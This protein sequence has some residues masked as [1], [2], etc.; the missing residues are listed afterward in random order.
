MTAKNIVLVSVLA[1]LVAAYLFSSAIITAR[2]KKDAAIIPFESAK[3]Q[4]FTL[5]NGENYMTVRREPDS[6]VFAR[7][8]DGIAARKETVEM[9]FKV[10]DKLSPIRRLGVIKE[11]ELEDFGILTKSPALAVTVG[12]KT[13]EFVLGARNPV[14]QSYYLYRKDTGELM[15][16]AEAAARLFR[17]RPEDFRDKKL[18]KFDAKDIKSM[19]IVIK[20]S[21]VGMVELRSHF[22]KA[23][24]SENS[25]FEPSRSQIGRAYLT[26]YVSRIW[27]WRRPKDEFAARKAFLKRDLVQKDWYL[28]E[29]R[30]GRLYLCEMA[31]VGQFIEMMLAAEVND[32]AAADDNYSIAACGLVSPRFTLRVST[33]GAATT[34]SLGRRYNG[35]MVYAAVDGMVRGGVSALL[36][37]V[38]SEPASSFA[39]ER[40]L[41]FNISSIVSFTVKESDMLYKYGKKR[42]RWYRTGKKTREADQDAVREFLQ[43]LA[44]LKIEKHYFDGLPGEIVREYMFYNRKNELLAGIYTGDTSDGITRVKFKDKE[45]TFGV[46]GDIRQLLGM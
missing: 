35:N 13:A 26:K 4:S 39:R 43:T 14:A 9:Y 17:Q 41:D 46:S 3:I 34:L 18:F 23:L 24:G 7:P 10:L 33:G 16:V 27:Q 37:D 40:L 5:Y 8:F 21:P 6:F 30:S 42:G 19:E 28:T 11:S 12:D 15:L 36:E 38:L 31:R 22:K 20:G 44:G 25:D 2:K 1:L 45:G 29:M 32:F